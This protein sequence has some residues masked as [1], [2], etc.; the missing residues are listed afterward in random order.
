MTLFIAACDALRT[1][2]DATVVGIHH[3]SRAGNMRGSTVFDGAGDFLLG[4]EREEGEMIGEIHA[5]KIKSAQDGWKQSFELMKRPVGDIVGTE[6]LVAKPIEEKLKPSNKWPEKE[7][8]RRVL[9]EMNRAW[10]DKNPWVLSEHARARGRNASMIMSTK[11]GM[12]IKMAKQIVDQW[13]I[14]EVIK[15]EMIDKHTKAVGL[16][17]IGSID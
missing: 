7:V 1:T 8:L 6:S 16:K 15:E 13:Q 5:K 2:F 9:S 4:I 10:I 14:N 12:P 3:T 11:Y 17:V